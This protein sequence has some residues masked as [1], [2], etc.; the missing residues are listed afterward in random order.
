MLRPKDVGPKD[1][2]GLSDYPVSKGAVSG[3][4]RYG[5]CGIHIPNNFHGEPRRFFMAIWDG[6]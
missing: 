3:S 1:G 6:V 4:Y 5:Y 2:G